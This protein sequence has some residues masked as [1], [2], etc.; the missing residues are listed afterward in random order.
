[1]KTKMYK[2]ELKM[3]SYIHRLWYHF[4]LF[5]SFR[6]IYH[7]HRAF[8]KER[9]WKITVISTVR[10]IQ[11][12]RV[13]FHLSYHYDNGRKR[14]ELLLMMS[15]DAVWSFWES[16]TAVRLVRR[17]GNCVTWHDTILK[18]T[19]FSV[20]TSRFAFFR[21]VKSVV[22]LRTLESNFSRFHED[23]WISFWLFS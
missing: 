16:K 2:F 9:R 11:S 3:K 18:C 19:Q 5:H 20:S 10:V 21:F 23:E 1:M 7:H 6:F 17:D 14:V 12:S 13:I 22:F 8:Q 15:Y 4:A